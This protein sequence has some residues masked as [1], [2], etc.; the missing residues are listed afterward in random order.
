MGES[1]EKS[2]GGPVVSRQPGPSGIGTGVT[3]DWAISAELLIL[4]GLYLAGLNPLGTGALGS[5]LRALAII[6]LVIG[7]LP[8]VALGEALRRGRRW[9]WT[10]QIVFNALL[11]PVG[12][13]GLPEAISS[14]GTGHF[15]G[16]VRSFVETVISAV[17]I[18]LLVRP[19]TRAWV[20]T[21][22]SQDAA[23]RHSG[24]WIG[25]IAVGAV[26]G[27]AAIALGAYY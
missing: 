3:F 13:V 5:G 14:A 24:V 1:K 15:S 16:L 8:T 27:G 7:A 23:A 11:V 19:S 2:G 20:G 26:I 12:I 21:V 17:L 4:A 18:W 25:Q 10:L 9:A 6:G 22:S